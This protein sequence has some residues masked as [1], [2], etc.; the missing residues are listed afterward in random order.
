MGLSLLPAFIQRYGWSLTEKFLNLVSDGYRKNAVAYACIRLHATAVAEASLRVYAEKTDRPI[1]N[2]PVR[3]LLE[4]P[5]PYMTEFEFWELTVTNL[6]ICGRAPWWVERSRMGEALQLWPL[7]PDRCEPVYGDPKKGE[8][9]LKGWR[10]SVDG[11]EAWDLPPTDVLFFNLTDPGDDSGGM[12][13]GLGPL[14]VLAREVDTDNEA[15]SFVYNVLRNAAMPGTVISTKA[16]LNKDEADRLRENFKARYGA[17]HRG[18]PAVMDADSTITP[19]GHSM[20]DLE[21]PDLR[22]VSESRI[23]AAIGVPAILAGLKVGLDRS[24]F[25]NVQEA[26]RYFAE[27]TCSITWRRLSDQINLQLG[28]LKQGVI[29]T[30]QVARFDTAAV[31]ALEPVRVE[32]AQRMLDGLR[33]GSV[34]VDDHRVALGLDPLPDKKGQVFLRSITITEVRLED[35]GKPPLPIKPPETPDPNEPGGQGDAIEP[36]GEPPVEQLDPPAAPPKKTK[37]ATK[38]AAPAQPKPRD[39]ER[40]QNAVV[41]GAVVKYSPMLQAAFVAQGERVAARL[42]HDDTKA[43]WARA[44]RKDFGDHL[45][46]QDDSQEVDGLLTQL[47]TDV[48]ATAATDA[49]ALLGLGS[50][51]TLNAVTQQSVMTKLAR[52]IVGIDETTRADVA[53]LVTSGLDAGKTLQEIA[54]DLKGLYE[55]TY[56]GRSDTIA[57]TESGYAY[58][59]GSLA[60]YG[61]SGMVDEVEVYDGDVD[62]ACAEADGATWTTQEAA[63]NP[64]EHPNCTRGFSPIVKWPDLGAGAATELDAT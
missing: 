23:A 27:T 42:L 10:Y 58:N 48:V 2:H 43:L 15:T 14:Q 45:V 64:M 46:E 17:I 36:P 57:R 19:I 8:P 28:D 6:D 47:H 16:K 41:K 61:A 56:V 9:I 31:T 40:R 5:N 44:Q 55:E 3:K 60:S 12:I 24:T 33:A 25:S 26:R 51:W 62:L 1:D 32:R 7:R 37:K 39:M 59:W 20:S 63:D 18:E 52:L 30:G 22:N 35:M 29:G 4:R 34:M 38:A 49:G 13:G 11:T 53:R 54:A 21:F 50:G